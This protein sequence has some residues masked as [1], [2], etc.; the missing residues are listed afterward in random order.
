MKLAYVI[1]AHKNAPQVIRLIDRLQQPGNTFVLHVSTTSEKGFY[2]AIH[3]QVKTKGYTNVHFC[4]R[5]DGTHNSFGIIKG[6]INGLDYLLKNKV[7][8]D[9]VSIISGQ[10][11]PIK[12]NAYIN[13]FFEQNKGKEFIEYFPLFPKPGSPE[14]LSPVW[15]KDKQTYRVTR[16]HFKIN[17]VVRS[18]PEL[19]TERLVM[20]PLIKTLKIF[21]HEAPRYYKE[22]RLGLEMQ[23]LFWSRV[24]PKR[25]KLPNQ[26]EL[27]GGKTWWTVTKDCAAY[28]IKRHYADS[29]LRKFFMFTLIP[30][31]MYFQTM[32]MSSPFKDKCEN[33][34]LR[35][36]EW[37]E[38]NIMHPMVFKL[39]HFDKI[40]NS[41]MLFARKFESDIDSAI[42]DK[43][44][45]E[46][47]GK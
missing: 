13:S 9:Y 37:N 28:I 40:K 16:H 6:I 12:S 39:A 27:Y 26:F 41:P 44:D 36:I 21:L 4:K 19:E 10:D 7:D 35:L 17:G 42:L 8:F 30:D 11:Y 38:D 15:G 32:L 25:R 1:T 34:Y 29:K 24:L 20:H 22:G 31:E 2:N 33:N 23:L 45:N 3:T 47:L 5:E 18:I 14:S 46:I 43:I